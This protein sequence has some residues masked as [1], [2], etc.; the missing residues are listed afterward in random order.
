MTG[1]A[2]K[3]VF[4]HSIS[5]SFRVDI[6]DVSSSVHSI[7]LC[8]ILMLVDIDQYNKVYSINEQHC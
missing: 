4:M 7:L 5:R 2:F 6:V 3:A 8:F 1:G